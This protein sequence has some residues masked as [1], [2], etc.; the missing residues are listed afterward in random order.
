MSQTWVFARPIRKKC[1]MSF[2]SETFGSAWAYM[3]A[4]VIAVVIIV[5]NRK[6]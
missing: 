4:I 6:V 2:M 3:V 1:S 5:I